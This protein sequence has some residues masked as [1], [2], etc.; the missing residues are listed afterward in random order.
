M[1]YYIISDT[2]F[3]HKKIIEYGRPEN[4][5]ALLWREL[6]IVQK[7]DILICL[8]DVCFGN[9]AE[10][11]EKINTLIDGKKILV[12]GNHD[13][14][15][16]KWYMDHGWNFVCDGFRLKYCGKKLYFSHKPIHYNDFYDM[17]IHGHFHTIE[18]PDRLLEFKD[19]YDFNYHKLVSMEYSN[20][21][22]LVLDDI[23]K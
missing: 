6:K 18:R 1:K 21:K 19:Y 17:N 13:N 14:K 2:H 9:D 5:E 8:G 15:S 23:I 11:H 22:P 12:K 20:Y 10:I 3:G 16:T 7:D 4:Y